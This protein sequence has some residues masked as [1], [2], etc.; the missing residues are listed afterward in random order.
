MIER[1]VY[2]NNR[3]LPGKHLVTFS[4][5]QGLKEV[6]TGNWQHLLQQPAPRGNLGAAPAPSTGK[7][8]TQMAKKAW[9]QQ[10]GGLLNDPLG[11]AVEDQSKVCQ[12]LIHRARR[13]KLAPVPSSPG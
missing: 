9:P 2:G 11:W 7:R 6:H 13:A 5:T 3:L 10:R 4:C 1:L 12:D 8:T